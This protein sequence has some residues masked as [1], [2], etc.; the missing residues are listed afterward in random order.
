MWTRRVCLRLTWPS[1]SKKGRWWCN[2]I[3]LGFEAIKYT[4]RFVDQPCLALFGRGDVTARLKVKWLG[5]LAD[6]EAAADWLHIP[7]AA[8]M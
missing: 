8:L 4:G 7:R 3:R 5:A 2:N 1:P 6:L